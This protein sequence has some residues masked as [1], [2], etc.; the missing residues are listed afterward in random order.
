VSAGEELPKSPD[1]GLRPVISFTLTTHKSTQK[2]ATPMVTRVN[3]SP[4]F[5]PK[6][7]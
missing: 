6:A 2:M 3:K 7:L 1:S 5:V 4:A